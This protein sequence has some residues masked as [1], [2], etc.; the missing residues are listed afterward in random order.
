MPQRTCRVTDSLATLDGHDLGRPARLTEN[1]V[2]GDVAPPARGVLAVGRAVRRIR[3][4]ADQ[5]RIRAATAGT[6]AARRDAA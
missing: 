1:P 5:V 6:A 3:D 2:I 4:P